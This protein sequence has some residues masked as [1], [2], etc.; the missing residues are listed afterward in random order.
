MVGV[1]LLALASPLSAANKDIERLQVQIAALQGQFSDLQR[2]AEENLKELRRL[3]EA[4]ADQNAFVKKNVQ[5]HQMQG[6][7]L[8][9]GLRELGDRVAELRDRVGAVGSSSMA[10]L[11]GTGSPG[12]STPPSGGG[13][14]PQPPAPR[15]LYSQAY[16]DYARGNYDLAMQEFQEYLRTY[17]AMELSDSAQHWIAMCLFAKQRY[18][19]AINAWNTMLREYPSSAKIPEAR[20]RKGMALERVGRRSQALA[21]YRYVLDRFPNSDAA[22]LA[23]E[24]LNP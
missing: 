4:L 23:R 9:A 5:D 7:T 15:E 16:A 24:K 18:E 6:E 12:S 10:P 14:S 3:N 22:R 2:L 21:E 19:D 1:T 20:V 13:S 8:K 11:P 17:P